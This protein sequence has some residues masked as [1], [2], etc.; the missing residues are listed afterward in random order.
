MPISWGKSDLIWAFRDFFE[1]I[2][3][4]YHFSP[5][6]PPPSSWIKKWTA[7]ASFSKEV[8]FYQDFFLSYSLRPY[9]KK[10]RFKEGINVFSKVSWR[11]INQVEEKIIASWY[12][13]KK[14]PSLSF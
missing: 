2:F 11:Q 8:F 7:L 9:H 3:F 14:Y 13:K 5:P 12:Y 10:N 1:T 6:P 4:T